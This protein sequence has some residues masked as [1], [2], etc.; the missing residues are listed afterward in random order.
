MDDE[1]TPLPVLD[2]PGLGQRIDV[3]H[4]DWHALV[5]DDKKRELHLYGVTEDRC[6]L[7][8]WETVRPPERQPI[9][10]EPEVYQRLV[11][12]AQQLD[13][14]V[15]L[16]GQVPGEALAGVDCEHGIGVELEV[17]RVWVSR[18]RALMPHI[19]KDGPAREST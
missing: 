1:A 12:C 13:L 2:G 11:V 7:T 6:A 19:F 10:V 17:S 15:D 9:P 8:H 14:L 16:V 18:L 3:G 4:D 5:V